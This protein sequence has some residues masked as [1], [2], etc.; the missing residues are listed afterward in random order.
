MSVKEYLDV[1]EEG[2][3]R[4]MFTEGKESKETERISLLTKLL[5]GMRDAGRDQLIYLTPR[6]LGN[7]ADIDPKDYMEMA[8]KAPLDLAAIA[9]A[10]IVPTIHET[11]S[12]FQIDLNPF[13]VRVN[14]G[15]TGTIV[16]QFE[17][18]EQQKV[19]TEISSEDWKKMVEGVGEDYTLAVFL[20]QTKFLPERLRSF[21]SGNGMLYGC[22]PLLDRYELTAKALLVKPPSK[23]Q[24]S[25]ATSS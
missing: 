24:V 7:A 12:T 18:T 22:L 13:A 17:L 21:L 1:L 11:V 5:D 8:E 16:K 4:T 14:R 10:A 6:G 20:R 15:F 23:P 9:I 19:V 2:D 3:I 25:E